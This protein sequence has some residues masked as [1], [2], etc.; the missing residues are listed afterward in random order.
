MSA[1]DH[2]E[3]C[4]HFENIYLLLNIINENY[5]EIMEEELKINLVP[6][7][8]FIKVLVDSLKLLNSTHHKQK[9]LI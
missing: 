2:N 9:M 8:E 4:F 7:E 3:T 6:N 5:L 1:N